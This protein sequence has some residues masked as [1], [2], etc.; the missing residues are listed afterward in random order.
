[1]KDFVCKVKVLNEAGYKEAL[2]GVG[3]NKKIS[4]PYS[5]YDD[6]PQDGKDQLARVATTLA[7]QDGGHNKFLEHIIIWLDVT[8]PRYLWQEMDTFRL[9]SKNS[10][11]TMHTLVKELETGCIETIRGM[12]EPDSIADFDIQ[13]LIM[14][15]QDEAF[16]KTE[17]LLALKRQIPEGFLQRRMWVMSYKTLRNI[18]IQRMNHRLPHWRKF[19]K[20]VYAQLQH[21]DLLPELTYEDNQ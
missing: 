4:S 1:M 9:S 11:S 6:I 21:S 20:D 3:F 18:S 12:F 2:F 10:E 14:I 7:S 5:C 19:L 8:A 13:G 15:A 17:R 16:S